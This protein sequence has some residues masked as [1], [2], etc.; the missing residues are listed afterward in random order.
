MSQYDVI[1]VGAGGAGAPLA[2]RLS[3]DADRTVL[4]LEAGKD[5][6]TTDAF[7]AELQDASTVRAM[8]PGYPADWGFTGNLI[9]GYEAN[10]TRGKILGGSTS[11][12]GTYFLRARKVDFDAWSAGGNDLWSYENVLRFYKRSETDLDFGETEQ[13]G[14]SGQM[15][16][17]RQDVSSQYFTALFSAAREAGYP[18]EQDKNG[19]QAPGMGR[20]VGNNPDGLRWNTGIGYINPVRDSRPNLTVQGETFVRRVVIKDGRAVGVEVEVAD[21]IRLITADRVVLSAGAMKTPHI[22]LLSG[23][24][25]A[26]ELTRAG[27]PVVHDLSGVGKHFSDHPN[28]LLSWHSKVPISDYANPA[29]ASAVLNFD[30]GETGFVEDLEVTFG[31]KTYAYLMSGVQQDWSPEDAFSLGIVLQKQTS[32]GD[33]TIVSDDPHVQ[34]RIDYNYFSTEEDRRRVRIAIRATV[35]LMTGNALSGI[36]GRWTDLDE[37]TLQDD[38]LLDAY[39]MSHFITGIHM[40]GTAKFAVGVDPTAVV[41]QY[42]SV[43]GIEGLTVADTSLL[44]DATS[45][46]PAATAVMIGELIA[47][48]LASGRLR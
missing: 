37:A 45:R 43:R 30:S 26:E 21:E 42:G 40:V 8:M 22:L 25:P 47:D 10:V 46:G 7:P 19:E 17:R 14:G 23:I 3:E 15:R 18:D 13:H 12:N 31:D 16:V 20:L 4:L 32:R 24:G 48:H 35:A 1:V 44:P 27:V 39:Y 33:F 38:A 28:I 29:I 34:P 6:V 36:F 5:Y 41:D 2:A 11:L 9:D